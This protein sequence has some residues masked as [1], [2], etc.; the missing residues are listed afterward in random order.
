M[1]HRIISDGNGGAY[2]AWSNYVPVAVDQPNGTT[3]CAQHINASGNL[4]WPNEL[5]KTLD[6]KVGYGQ[7]HYHFPNLI[8]LS[9]NDLVI[10]WID[11]IGNVVTNSGLFVNKI[12]ANGN[13]QWGTNGVVVE[14]GITND[15]NINNYYEIYPKFS[16]NS[17]G[18]YVVYAGANKLKANFITTNGAVALANSLLISSA[19]DTASSAAA[20]YNYDITSDSSGNAIVL[21]IDRDPANT[22]NYIPKIQKINQVGSLLFG[23]NG[24]SIAANNCNSGNSLYYTSYLKTINT[25]D[26]NHLAVWRN[27]NNSS[28][29]VLCQKFDDNGQ[30]LFVSGGVTLANSVVPVSINLLADNNGGGLIAFSDHNGYMSSG[31][32][33][34]V[35]VSK[36]SAT[37]NKSIDLSLLLISIN[38]YIY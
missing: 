27:S 28:T 3:I 31:G 6:L 16:L 38:A 12:D 14:S 9:T 17:N 25:T 36:I 29:R 30:F 10:G 32:E 34:D 11:N 18:V 1:E 35:Y 19:Y 2:L 37:G 15:S 20:P 4:Q 21:Y 24:L 22:S 13:L 23:S 5:V 8:K 33:P 26:G 7:G